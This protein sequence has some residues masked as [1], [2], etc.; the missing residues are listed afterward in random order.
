MLKHVNPHRKSPLTLSYPPQ[1]TLAMENHGTSTIY[2]YFSNENIH[3][4]RI[5]H[6]HVWLPRY[7]FIYIYISIY[8]TKS[9]LYLYYIPMM[10]KYGWHIPVVFHDFPIEFNISQ[11]AIFDY[12]R[13]IPLITIDHHQSSLII[14]NHHEKTKKE[15]HWSSLIIINHH[16]KTQQ[17]KENPPFIDDIRYSQLKTSMIRDLPLIHWSLLI[18]FDHSS[19]ISPFITINHH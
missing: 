12:R 16:L 5:Y 13:I 1:S 14:V 2:K 17:K 4:S 9:L 7:A 19:S 6:C 3:L 18:T 11:P 15:K 10:M 8:P